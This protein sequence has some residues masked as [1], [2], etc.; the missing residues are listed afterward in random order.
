MEAFQP[1]F[2]N[3]THKAHHTYFKYL[4]ETEITYFKDDS[5][6]DI[7]GVFF[8]VW[9]WK[10]GLYTIAVILVEA[11]AFLVHLDCFIYLKKSEYIFFNIWHIIIMVALGFHLANTDFQSH[12]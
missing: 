5:S 7:V 3:M 6:E 1:H 4:G 2:H 8:V 11:I 10:N 9:R 12:N